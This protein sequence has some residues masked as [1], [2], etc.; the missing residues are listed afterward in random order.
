MIDPLAWATAAQ[1]ADYAAR[2]AE[3]LYRRDTDEFPAVP[4]LPA[5]AQAWLVA[6]TAWL[7]AQEL[8]IVAD[9]PL[10]VTSGLPAY[11]AWRRGVLAALRRAR[12][13][14][15]A[16][17]R[18]RL[19]VV[20]RA[21]RLQLLSTWRVPATWPP[22]DVATLLRFLAELVTAALG[23]P[24]TAF[25]GDAEVYWLPGDGAPGFSI[26]LVESEDEDDDA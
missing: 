15:T 17:R 1:R 5:A 9:L 19:D 18:R 16:E 12:G 25:S 4:A 10:L 23:I 6:E 20:A 7:R 26:T 21:G 22:P 3:Y 8:L 13:A 11:L 24:L 2:R 14:G